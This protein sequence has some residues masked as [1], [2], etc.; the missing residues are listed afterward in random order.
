M[1]IY[2]TEPLA[3]PFPPVKTEKTEQKQQVK[4]SYVTNFVVGQGKTLDDVSL[5]RIATGGIVPKVLG[6]DIVRNP[7]IIW[8]GNLK[9]VIKNVATQNVTT[10]ESG[11]Q[12]VT[13]TITSTVTAYTVDIQF[14]TGLGPGQRLRSIYLDNVAIWT[15]TIGPARTDFS[16]VGNDTIS[17]VTYA[18]GNFDQAVDMYLDGLISEQLSGYRGFAYVIIKSLDTTKLGNLAFEVDSY[19]DPLGLGVK[20]KIGEDINP[21]SA[22]VDLITNTWGG[23]GQDISIIGSSFTAAGNTLYDEGNGCSMV[24]RQSVS[25]NSLNAIFLAQ[26][27]GTIYEDHVTGKI[28]IKLYRKGFDRSN[29]VRVFDKDIVSISLD[30]TSW[31]TVPTN[32]KA[33]YVDRG[34]VY[35]EIPLIARN[36]ATSEKI[37][38]SL[39]ELSYPAVRTGTLAAQLLSRD[40][41]DS[42]SP[43]QQ[44]TLTTDRRTA[45]LNPGDIFL[46]TCSKYKYYGVP[47]VVSKR[48]TQPLDD[49]KVTLTCNVYLYPNNN[50]LFAAPEPSF[51]VPIDPNPHPPLSVKLISTPQFMRQTFTAVNSPFDYWLGSVIDY[52]E[53]TPLVFGEAYNPSQTNMGGYYNTGGVDTRFYTGIGAPV[54]PGIDFGYPLFGK[55]TGS[56]DK[57]DNWDGSQITIT[58]HDLNPNI[59]DYGSILDAYQSVLGQT[60]IIFIDDEIFVFDHARDFASTSITINTGLHTLVLTGCRRAY[61]D[62]VAQSHAANTPVYVMSLTPTVRYESKVTFSYG[63]TP[64]FKFVGA[65]YP[66]KVYTLSSISTALAYSGWTSNDRA[67]RPLRPHNTKIDGARDATPHNLTRGATAAITW[68]VRSRVRQPSILTPAFQ[69]DA[70]QVGEVHSGNHIVYRVFI[71]DSAAVSWDCG[72]TSAAAD[73]DNKTIT[74]PA[75]AA[76]GNGWLYVQAEFDAGSGNRVSSYQDRLPVNLV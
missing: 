42:G 52:A 14:C 49:S 3:P 2:A 22:I 26:V 4:K 1:T 66:K 33:S 76:A 48:R 8:Y 39:Q 6:R 70:N 7:D 19:P 53:D 69:T 60:A 41:A 68:K 47:A 62:T 45:G 29:L 36:L 12:T 17:D 23:A 64:N 40:G 38:K 10:D 63:T 71:I 37:S 20:N 54:S 5:P 15:G 27:D 59:Q 30:K 16:V 73:T 57:Y 58:L 24:N 28:E 75:G 51:F 35:K 21:V 65:A 61:G 34:L 56:I 32:L 67:R 31:Q 43:V 46:I 25:A 9:P 50:V 18:G 72:T 74:V 13:T 44:V 55:L 11:N